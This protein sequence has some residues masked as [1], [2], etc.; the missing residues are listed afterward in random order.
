MARVK[1]LWHDKT[2]KRTARYGKG[3]RWQGIWT[4]SGVEV[5]RSFETKAGAEEHLVW[6]K[7]NQ[8][9]GTYV[10]AERGRVFIRDIIDD[11]VTAQAHVSPSTKAAIESDVRAT[12]KPYWGG[13]VLGDVRREQ[14]QAWV[15]SMDKAAR[16]V[17]TIYGRFNTFLKW[18]VD[19]GRLTTNPATGVNLPTG[20]KR[21]HLFLTVA[22]VEALATTIGE[23]YSGLV[24]VL[25]TTGLRMGE[26]CELRVK[27]VD[28][29]RKRL[30]IARSVVFVRGTAVVGP[31]KNK[32]TRTVPITA[33]AAGILKKSIKDKE[34]DDL[35][36][37]TARGKQIRGSNFKRRDY[38]GAVAAVRAAAAEQR[39]KGV[40]Q[41][42]TIPDG[43]WVHDLRHTAASWAVQSGASV[44]SV[45]RM[46]GHAT[47]AMTLDVYAGLFDQDLDDVVVKM[48]LL[49]AGS[50]ET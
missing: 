12:I 29:R 21:E 40:K 8:L 43:L 9:S 26:L 48:D 18:C 22:Q 47:A 45:Q 2:K 39:V 3:Q 50:T 30:T 32:K 19:H 41:P 16:T 25:A 44:K 31:P 5:K 6:V 17:D 13:K 27:D 49:I 28:L 46:L 34:R 4:E 7:H 14:V 24:W 15:S 37:I 20:N 38:D 42:L 11:W 10:S 35:V 23:R 33:K 1:D 36:F